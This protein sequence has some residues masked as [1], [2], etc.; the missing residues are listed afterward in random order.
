[1]VYPQG[2]VYGA[3]ILT[4]WCWGSAA[5]INKLGLSGAGMFPLFFALIREVC[6]VPLL[7]GIIAV[8]KVN[9]RCRKDAVEARGLDT[10]SE[11]SAP[12]EDV[13]GLPKADTG[14]SSRGKQLCL[15]FLPGLFIFV[16][17]LCSLT[18][19]TLADPVSGAAWQPSQVVF[20]IIIS[21][22]LGMEMLTYWKFFGMLLTIAG[23]L[24]LVFFAGSSE[25]TPGRNPLVGQFFFLFNCL[26]SSLE[27]ITWRSILRDAASGQES[28]RVMAESYLVASGLMVS[29][30]IG[31][32][33]STPIVDF[34]CP[35]CEGSAW[36]LPPSAL[37]AVAYSAVFQ[38]IIAYCA[39]AWALRY[40]E[41]SLASLYATAQ[42]IMAAICTC[43]FLLVGFN[44]GGV[45]DWPGKEMLGALPIVAGLFVSQCGVPSPIVAGHFV[46]PSES[47]DQEAELD[48]V[49]NHGD[50]EK[51]AT[52]SSV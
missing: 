15:R 24:M 50:G 48:D 52:A 10:G 8:V 45:L 6:A 21:T 18:G 7:F 3:L 19:V 13:A 17:Q 36:H 30:C 44:P 38:T 12:S 47:E 39:Q 26:A 37:W 20:T 31:A 4:Q 51:R 27:V 43:A 23:A 28:F 9:E 16:D 5:V 34:V 22:C 2:Q 41:S 11:A 49:E 40:A 35:E 14:A 46:S 25:A 33:F 29:A 1:M 42:P 32:S